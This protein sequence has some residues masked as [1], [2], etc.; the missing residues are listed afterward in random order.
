LI[1]KPAVD[2]FVEMRRFNSEQKKSQERGQRNDE[3]RGPFAFGEGV[4]PG[5]EL[6]AENRKI[7]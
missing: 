5:L 2:A 1:D 6:S 7:R 4:F 3:P